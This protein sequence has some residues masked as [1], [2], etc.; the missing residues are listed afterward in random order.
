MK[1]VL[2]ID[3]DG[4]QLNTFLGELEE[5]GVEVVYAEKEQQG[6][7][8]LAQQNIDAILMDGNLCTDRD[9]VDVVK[10]LRAAGV[11]TKIIMFSSD[12]KLNAAGIAAGANGSWNKKLFRE[13]GWLENLLATLG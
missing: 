9:G 13:K 5:H 3:D 6:I 10:T 2:L 1:K 11:T 7:D 4:Q 8:I 12:E